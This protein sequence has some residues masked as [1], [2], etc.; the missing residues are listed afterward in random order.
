MESED[1]LEYVQIKF[2][3]FAEM[4]GVMGRRAAVNPPV[5]LDTSDL[6]QQRSSTA[7]TAE[8]DDSLPDPNSPSLYARCSHA[9]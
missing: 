7:D 8:E 4:H 5:L 1:D 3:W 6:H 9:A 2:R